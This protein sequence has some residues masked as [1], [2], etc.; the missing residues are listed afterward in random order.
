MV[1]VVVVVVVVSRKCQ[2]MS[3]TP[4]KPISN[5]LPLFH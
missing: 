4:R 3:Y 2:G 5:P 1:V